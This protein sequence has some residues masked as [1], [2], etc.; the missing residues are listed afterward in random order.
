MKEWLRIGT[1]PI[2]RQV[3]IVLS[4][5]GELFLKRCF[6]TGNRSLRT[7]LLSLCLLGCPL[8]SPMAATTRTDTLESLDSRFQQFSDAF[9]K[10]IVTQNKLPLQKYKTAGELKPKVTE[11]IRSGK[12]VH[13]LALIHY[14]LAAITN[15]IDAV[16]VIPLM[17]VLLD[18]NDW[19]MAKHIAELARSDAGKSANSNISF[20]FA[21]YFMQRKDWLR[22]QERLDD[23]INELSVENANYARLMIGTILQHQKKHRAAITVYK[24]IN[25]NSI[26]YP[27]AVL[28]TAVAYI[29]QDW[30]TDAHI[31][32]T[33]LLKNPQSHVKDVMVDRLNLV[34]GYA[35]LRKEYFRNS[36]DVFRNVGLNSPYTNKA[37]LGIALTAA[38]QEDFIGSL[39]AITMLKEKKSTDLS[40]DESYLLLPYTYGKLKQYLT[41]SSAYTDAIKYY[42]SRIAELQAIIQS[43]DSLPTL[44]TISNNGHDL[45]IKNNTFD[46]S[47]RYPKS[48]FTNYTTLATF[49]PYMADMQGL[50]A[51]Y[52]KLLGEYQATLKT[53]S[54]QLLDQRIEFL[55]SYLNQARYGLARLYDSSLISAK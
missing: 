41:A 27:S 31:I 15:N 44:V 5:F 54:L 45:T 9:Y 29:R 7:I 33:D 53:I 14:N 37:L 4:V 1:Q 47:A 16:D 17:T 30:W 2:R 28:N 24:Q 48:F 12:S 51:S 38:N 36:R 18:H 40:V 10:Q 55:Q 43:G 23:V 13:A 46:Y 52:N 49:Q 35:L 39:N 8:S 50:D 34:L 32:I 25:K 19:L 21:R 3:S 20:E 22:A 11:L 42:Q 6:T 26:Y